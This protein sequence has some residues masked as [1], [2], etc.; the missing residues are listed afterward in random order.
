L[1]GRH[2]LYSVELVYLASVL[3][4]LAGCGI[5]AEMVKLISKELQEKLKSDQFSDFW[6]ATKDDVSVHESKHY[7]LIWVTDEGTQIYLERAIEG[8]SRC[9]RFINI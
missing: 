6:E 7:L 8:S 5:S 2:R 9:P 3:L 4:W 1:S